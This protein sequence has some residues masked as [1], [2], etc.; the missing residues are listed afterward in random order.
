MA[1]FN[2]FIDRKTRESKKQLKLLKKVLENQD[3]QV[4]DHLDEE[5]PYIF[6][7]NPNKSSFDGIRIYKKLDVIS[8]R[9]QKE[10]T[11]HPYGK[12]Y[13]LDIEEMYEDRL[14]DGE[15][16]KKAGKAVM[17]MVAEELK[18]F[19]EKSAEAEKEIRTSAFDDPYSQVMVKTTGTD[20]SNLVHRK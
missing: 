15:D 2:E 3:F 6:V 4:K 13:S 19:F 8:F 10:E 1:R 11:T 12:A 18:D 14:V 7:K 20:Y 17:K 5:D 9:I 16:V